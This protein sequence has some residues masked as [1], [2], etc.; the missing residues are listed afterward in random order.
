MKTLIVP[1]KY[2]KK[3]ISKFLLDTFPNLKK[4]T[5]YQA[6]RK[7]D[8][9]LN[10][11]RIH[12]DQL[13]K[14][15]DTITLYIADSLLFSDKK[16]AVVYEDDHILVVDKPISTEITG[17]HS[18][19]T[20]VQESYPNANPCHRLDR[21]TTGLVLFA[22]DDISLAI[23]LEKFKKR[24]IEK[25]YFAKVYGIPKVNHAILDAYLFKDRKKAMVY[26]IDVPKQGYQKIQTEYTLLSKDSKE[27]TSILDITLH[28]GKTHQ[29]RAHLAHIGLPII[30]DGKYGNN[31]I[32]KQF[33]QKTQLLES[34]SLTFHFTSTSG[35]LEYLNGKE[36]KKA[37]SF[38]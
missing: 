24:E 18:L 28:T 36:F 31:Q 7:K 32:N 29:I 4:G 5:F 8:I 1:K 9:R 10:D 23:L 22:K 14:E 27:N 30:G 21:N 2:E 38:I 34:Y 3:R 25:K 37:C 16:L 12:Q 35:I 13:I 15:K 19:T 17:P 33:H 11:K 20:L 6:L 26:I